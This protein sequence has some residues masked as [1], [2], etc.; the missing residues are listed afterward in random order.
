MNKIKIKSDNNQ[1]CAEIQDDIM[2]L[3]HNNRF[4]SMH[5][6]TEE[7]KDLIELFD[8]IKEELNSK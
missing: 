6:T 4:E 2:L 1:L 5:F 8:K 3:Y 7:L